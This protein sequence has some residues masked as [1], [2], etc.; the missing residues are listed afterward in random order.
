MAVINNIKINRNFQHGCNYAE[1]HGQATEV[2][3]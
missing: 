1:Q 3:V 2:H